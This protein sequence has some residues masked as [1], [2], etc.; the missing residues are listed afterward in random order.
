MIK[1]TQKI[2]KNKNLLP[3]IKKNNRNNRNKE[4]ITKLQN[5]KSIYN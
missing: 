4:I 5:C 1:E 3:K 2:A